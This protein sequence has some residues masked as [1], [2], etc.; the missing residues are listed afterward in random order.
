MPEPKKRTGAYAKI[1]DGFRGHKKV[2]KIPREIRAEAIGTWTLAL[3]YANESLSDGYVPE[4]MIDELA[5]TMRGAEALVDVTLWRR[6]RGGGFVFVNWAEHQSTRAE[7]EA[8]KSA[9]TERQR[10]HRNKGEDHAPVT[11]DNGATNTQSETETDTDTGR[12]SSSPDDDDQ[13]V[14]NSVETVR[15]AAA[16]LEKIAGE[17]V[18]TTQAVS[19]VDEI[20]DRGGRRVKNPIRYVLGTI[21][22]S[23]GEWVAYAFEGK[24]PA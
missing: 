6:R 13:H 24:V 19:V 23:P 12:L 10:R 20:L 17:P 5:G 3:S 21:D 2:A 22:K 1:F 15:A 9:A 14:D 7:V 18:T 8:K 16:R 11:R 4:H